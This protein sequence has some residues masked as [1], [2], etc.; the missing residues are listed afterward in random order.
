[1]KVRGSLQIFDEAGNTLDLYE[2]LC[3]Y[4]GHTSYECQIQVRATTRLP[5]RLIAYPVPEE[6]VIKRR[7]SHE[8][9]AQKHGR[10][11]SKKIFD[12]CG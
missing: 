12:V 8:R 4:A 2:V 5:A 11:P 7:T 10:K 6:V 3:T 1:M 9:K